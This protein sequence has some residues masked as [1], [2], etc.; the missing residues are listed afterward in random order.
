MPSSL[1]DISFSTASFSHLFGFGT[2]LLAANILHTVVY[3][4]YTFIIGKLYEARS[5]GIF[6]RGQ[7]F[8]TMFPS[9]MSNVI[10]QSTYPVF[11]QLQNDNIRLRNSFVKYVWAVFAITAPLCVMLA[12]L[13]KPVV[14]ILLTDKWIEIVRLFRLFDWEIVRLF[15]LFDWEIGRLVS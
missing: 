5:L 15:R 4:S 7:T 10:E 11:S 9:N 3:N 14:L 12:V 8:A 2:K 1:L 6:N 13:A